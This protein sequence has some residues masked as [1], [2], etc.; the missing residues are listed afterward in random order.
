MQRV[1]ARVA[2]RAASYQLPAAGIGGAAATFF[3]CGAYTY[4]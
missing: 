1:P 3:S 2:A 4:S